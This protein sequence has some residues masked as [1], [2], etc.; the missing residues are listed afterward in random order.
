MSGF[1][2]EPEDM[3]RATVLD[4]KL[5]ALLAGRDPAPGDEMAAELALMLD[6]VRAAFPAVVVSE[7]VE[8][9]HIARIVEAAESVAPVTAPMAPARSSFLDRMRAG[10][11]R[12]VA[13]ASLAFTAAFGGAAYAG[14][15]PDPVQRA[16][17]NAAGAVGV[18]LPKP[19]D[20]DDKGSVTGN[21][22]RRDERDPEDATNG[23][24]ADDPG[25]SDAADD[26]SSRGSE[27]DRRDGDDRRGSR[28]G[29][30]GDR[31]DGKRGDGDARA[32]SD[33]DDDGSRRRSGGGASPAGDDGD[34]VEFD[35]PRHSRDF[36]RDDDVIEPDEDEDSS[37]GK[38][39]EGDFN[40]DDDEF[41][42]DDDV[43]D[44]I[45]DLDD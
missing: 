45:D 18:E 42:I 6:E 1:G 23:P 17:S 41:E 12:R 9:A 33:G 21:D 30:S 39:D 3:R 25:S 32:D 13:A 43:A 40:D 22:E 36:D 24:G 19:G 4:K 27:D 16:V 10:L 29:T 11:S 38:R 31:T 7:Q 8:D 28:A 44:D 5:D 2:V 34:D 20:R 35:E 14:A 37:S 26:R 15:L